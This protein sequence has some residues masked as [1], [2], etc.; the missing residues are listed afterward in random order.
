VR[1]FPAHVASNGRA[2]EQRTTVGESVTSDR[3]DGQHCYQGCQSNAS[4]PFTAAFTIYPDVQQH[5]VSSPQIIRYIIF[6]AFM[7]IIEVY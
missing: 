3:K 7:K 2:E 5:D 6:R 1:Q 4:Y